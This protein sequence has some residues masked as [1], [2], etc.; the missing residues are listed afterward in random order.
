M[1]VTNSTREDLNDLLKKLIATRAKL[2]RGSVEDGLAGHVIDL[3]SI[4][5]N[6]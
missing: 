1:T 2:K 5:L 4:L 3:I 6:D